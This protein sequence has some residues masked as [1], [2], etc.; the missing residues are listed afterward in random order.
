MTRADLLADLADRIAKARELADE[1]SVFGPGIGLLPDH[2]G[3]G[4][5]GDLLSDL[6]DFIRTTAADAATAD[7]ATAAA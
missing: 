3:Y 7:A 2:F 4:N 6:E 5:A 1:I